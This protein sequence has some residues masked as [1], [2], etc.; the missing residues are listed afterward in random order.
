MLVLTSTTGN[1]GSRVLETILHRHL[2]PPSK[3]IISS[4][5]PEKVSAT[6]RDA[7]IEIRKGD[8]KS[9]ESLASSF[10]GADALFLVSFPS[11]NIE[12]WLFHKAAIDAAKAV[13]VKTIIYTSLMFGGK[14]GLESVAGVQQAHIKTIEYLR[15]SGLQY[16][17][18]REGIYAEYWSVYAGFQPKKYKKGDS[19]DIRFVISNDG[20]VAW[21]TTDDLA[22]G[23]AKILQHY[24]H[25]I[26][27]TLNLTGPRASSVSDIARIVGR[28][29]GRKV[30]VDIVGR[31]EAERYHKYEKKSLPEDMFWVIESWS[32][33]HDAMAHGETA[34]IDPLLGELLGRQPNGVE[35]MA[36]TYFTPE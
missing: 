20:P 9:P 13:G 31:E 19:D 15:Q 25:Y 2:I 1:L 5:K 34:E 12:R 32:G 27:R 28:Y 18:V 26:G 10:K 4:T 6:A 14:T 29:T 3:I 16:V 17:I 33:W 8:Y 36:E 11:A 21:V 7:G 23:N 22:E 30:K 24:Q 35:E